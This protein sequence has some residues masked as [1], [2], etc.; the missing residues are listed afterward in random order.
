MRIND[1]HSPSLPS[2]TG[3][4]QGSVLGPLLFSLYIND[5][6]SVCSDVSIQMYADDTVIYKHHTS[7][8][9]LTQSMVHV[10][11]WLN[12]CCLKLNVNK[13]VAMFFSRSNVAHNKSEVF[14]AGEKVQVVPEY[15]YLGVLIDSKLNHMFKK[16][17]IVP[18]SIF[19][20]FGS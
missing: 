12:Q 3:V 17:A 13:T 1:Q 18:N 8:G 5:L 20:I 16:S 7:C 2:S 15:K 14:V 6:P 4:P 9:K 10:T 19:Q 11:E